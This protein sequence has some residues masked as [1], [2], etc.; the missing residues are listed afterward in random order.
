MVL[1][2]FNQLHLRDGNRC[3]ATVNPTSAIPFLTGHTNFCTTSLLRRKR[4]V[5]GSYDE[6]IRFWDIETGEMKKCLQVKKPVSCVDFLAEE[7]T[8]NPIQQLAG[9]LNSIHAVVLSSKNLVSAGADKA[10]VCWDWRADTNLKIVRFGQQTTINIGVQLVSGATEEEGDRVIGVKIDGIVQVFSIK[11]QEMI[12]QF[13]LSELEHG[14]PVL[15]SKL[16][17]VGAAPNNVLQWFAAKR[18]QMTCTTKSAILHLQWQ[19][20]D[21]HEEPSLVASPTSSTIPLSAS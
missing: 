20:G 21:Q 16:A 7:V 17:N 13:K 6:T 3:I 14:D 11:R 18:T 12:S 9:H 2:L 10:L 5:S 19:E 15:N 4:L 1:L 8:F